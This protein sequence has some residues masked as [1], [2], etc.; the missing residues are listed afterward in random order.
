MKVK[1]L[2]KVLSKDI[3]VAISYSFDKGY[4]VGDE[5]P[6][7]VNDLN[8]TYVTNNSQYYDLVIHVD[9]NEYALAFEDFAASQ[10]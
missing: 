8:V 1:E 6:S 7:F 5:Y 4:E 10:A 3:K 2:L 9:Q